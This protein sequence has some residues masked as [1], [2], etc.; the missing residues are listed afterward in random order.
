MARPRKNPP[1]LLIGCRVPLETYKVIRRFSSTSE[2]IRTFGEV[3]GILLEEVE[4]SMNQLTQ[5]ISVVFGEQPVLGERVLQLALPRV[6]LTT[7]A[8]STPT[9]LDE[10]VRVRELLML[11]AASMRSVA[12]S[13]ITVEIASNYYSVWGK[14]LGC[15]L[16]LADA[17]CIAL[18][19]FAQ[20]WMS[21]VYAPRAESELVYKCLELF[22]D[23][24][25]ERG[26]DKPRR[27]ADFSAK[28]RYTAAWKTILGFLADPVVGTRRIA[29]NS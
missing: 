25:K 4:R 8:I 21:A 19:E 7:A 20:C 15:A 13:P 11:W 23:K 5:D 29:G 10:P 17:S 3:Y 26:Y 28:E 12:V 16:D 24:L 2:G 18:G 14:R 6:S 27:I 1:T 22:A 9:D